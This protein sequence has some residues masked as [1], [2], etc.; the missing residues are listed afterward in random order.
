MHIRLAKKAVSILPALQLLEWFFSDEATALRT[1]RSKQKRIQPGVVD[2]PVAFFATL[3]GISEHMGK[4]Q[5]IHFDNVLTNVG[6]AYNPHAGIF[7]APV[8]G[9]YVFSTTIFS[10]HATDGHFA[11]LRNG[12]VLTNLYL[13]PGSTNYDSTSMSLVLQLGKGDDVSV[14]NNDADR[15]INGYHYTCF[16]GFL[17]QELSEDSTALIGK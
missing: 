6:G 16:S 17:L 2:P 13:S 15:T 3:S 10:H 4:L 9:I 8:P 11:F 5:N 12:S 7:V 1:E 14:A